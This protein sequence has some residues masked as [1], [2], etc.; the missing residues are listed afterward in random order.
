MNLLLK[1]SGCRHNLFLLFETCA[2]A[3]THKSE[4][5]T[6]EQENVAGWLLLLLE[7]VP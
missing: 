6:A 2:E 1:I 3:L 7:Q 5:Y 4:L